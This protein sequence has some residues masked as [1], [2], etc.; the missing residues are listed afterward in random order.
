ML[1]SLTLKPARF[2]AARGEVGLGLRRLLLLRRRLK[3][4][5]VVV[6]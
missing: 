4:E 1:S 5:E 6:G 2:D 3:P